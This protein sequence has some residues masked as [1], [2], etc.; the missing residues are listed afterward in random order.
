VIVK[1][2][3][4]KTFFDDEVDETKFTERY[5]ASVPAARR[6]QI[7]RDLID[8]ARQRGAVTLRESS[9]YLYPL[10]G[11]LL[12]SVLG[13]YGPLSDLELAEEMLAVV[14]SEGKSARSAGLPR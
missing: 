7:V 14:F 2:E 8:R 4:E 1:L 5:Y 13:N 9:S 12:L 10:E 3:Y 11:E 6:A